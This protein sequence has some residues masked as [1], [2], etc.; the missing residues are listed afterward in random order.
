MI[1]EFGPNVARL[2]KQFNLSQ[3][4]LAERIGIQTQSIS[5]IERGTR[6]PTF[7]TMQRI[8]DV[9]HATPVQLF[10]T[11][12]EVAV[13]DTPAILDRID[14]Y[15]AKVAN[16]FKLSDLLDH[17]SLDT[18][19]ELITDMAEIMPWFVPTVKQKADGTPLLDVNGDPVMQRPKFEDLPLA[20]VGELVSQLDRIDESTGR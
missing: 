3:A 12:K 18:L 14:A 17:Y 5:N 1:D 20:A 11:P 16:L 4:E 13:A 2:R 8:A 7:E 10:G 19:D 6:Y 15:D 9:F